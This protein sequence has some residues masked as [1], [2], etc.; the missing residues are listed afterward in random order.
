MIIEYKMR[1]N[2]FT[3]KG[4]TQII[5]Q[6]NNSDKVIPLLRDIIQGETMRLNHSLHLSKKRLMRFESKYKITSE[7]FMT[8]WAAEDLPGADMESLFKESPHGNRIYR[9]TFTGRAS[10]G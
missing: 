5:L 2:G 8:E 10:F 3:Q 9:R 4:Y 6:T 7:K 1:H